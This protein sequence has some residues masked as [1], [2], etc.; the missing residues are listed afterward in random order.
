MELGLQ[1]MEDSDD[2]GL[3]ILGGMS[4]CLQSGAFL[5]RDL[6]GVGRQSVVAHS[7]KVLQNFF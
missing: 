4:Y 6:S 1:M 7:C 3:H 5:T 2:A